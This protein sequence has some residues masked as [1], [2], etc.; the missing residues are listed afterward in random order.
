MADLQGIHPS[1]IHSEQFLHLDHCI[2]ANLPAWKIMTRHAA[3]NVILI[4]F[5][6]CGKTTLGVRLAGLLGFEFIDTDALIVQKA[7]CSIPEIFAKEGEEGF[8]K[9]ETETLRELEGRQGLIISTGGGIVTRPENQEILRRLGVIVWI[10]TSDILLWNRVRR[11]RDRPM[12]HTK[13]PR[14]TFLD[15]LHQRKPLYEGLA[16]LVED[17]RGLN[18]EESA[19]GISESIR[20]FFSRQKQDAD[21][22]TQPPPPSV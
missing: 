5:M 20:V 21:R 15:L 12:L 2:N 7:G 13:N 14:K 10:T 22:D 19:Y 1:A 6:G 8:R 4:G 11:N 9:L 17:T 3:L 18:P 16:D